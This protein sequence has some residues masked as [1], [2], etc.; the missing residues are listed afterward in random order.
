MHH[1]DRQLASWKESI[2]RAG[3]LTV[4]DIAELETHV[5]DSVQ[6]LTA[7]GLRRR[8]RFLWR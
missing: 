2:T 8:K 5:R 6:Q 4:N 3:T 7:R 1:L